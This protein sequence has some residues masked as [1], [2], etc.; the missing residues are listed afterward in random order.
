MRN[1]AE[2]KGNELFKISKQNCSVT[3]INKKIS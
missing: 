2:E 1:H 3:K